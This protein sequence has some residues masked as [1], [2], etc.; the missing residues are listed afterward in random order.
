[1]HRRKQPEPD[2][3]TIVREFAELA[4]L[5]REHRPPLVEGLERRS[6][7]LR[8]AP[9]RA[10]AWTWLATVAPGDPATA[11]AAAFYS[12]SASGAWP[13]CG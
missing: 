13:A 3:A 5:V 1:M 6:V 9:A 4:A 2:V 7:G 10:S 12:P 8:G 11:A